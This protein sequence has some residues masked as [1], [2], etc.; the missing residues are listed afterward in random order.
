MLL[1]LIPTSSEPL[2]SQI[3]RQIRGFILSGTLAPDSELASIRAFAQQQKVSVITVQRAYDNLER[4]GFIL[5]RRG[6]PAI[7][8]H[9]SLEERKNIVRALLREQV[10]PILSQ[11]KSDGLTQDELISETTSMIKSLVY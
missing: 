9:L 5:T 6:K 11:A 10:Q 7:V 3:Y 2:H 1:H 4:A 8:A